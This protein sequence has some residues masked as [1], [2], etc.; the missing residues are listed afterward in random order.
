MTKAESVLRRRRSEAAAIACRA[1][2]YFEVQEV[3]DRG[4]QTVLK[5]KREAAAKKSQ[6]FLGHR[7]RTG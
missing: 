3:E 7:N 6:G 2:F 1:F 5:R 4:I